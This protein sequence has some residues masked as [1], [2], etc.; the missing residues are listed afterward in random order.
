MRRSVRRAD[1]LFYAIGTALFLA[2]RLNRPLNEQ[3]LAQL[4][5][6]FG[7]ICVSGGFVQQGMCE[8][9]H[10]EP[11]LG[12]LTRLCFDFNERDRGSL[13]ALIDFVNQPE[14]LKTPGTA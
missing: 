10:D 5:T 6:R 11:E 12:T 13:R 9:E 7:H 8:Q 4:D 3:A 1:R 2:L 14:N